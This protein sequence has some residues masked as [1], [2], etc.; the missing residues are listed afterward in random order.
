MQVI[1]KL[2]PSD[3]QNRLQTLSTGNRGRIAKIDF[4]DKTIIESGVLESINYDP[5]TKG[6]D[7]VL[8][9]DGYI[10]NMDY[11]KELFVVEQ[12]NGEVTSIKILDKKGL[13]T[14]VGLL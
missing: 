14:T 6:N 7:L 3:W 5:K 2:E 11:P 9:L 13:T 4:E 10:H 1:K 8:T 12:E